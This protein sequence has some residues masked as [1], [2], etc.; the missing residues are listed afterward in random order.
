MLM[1]LNWFHNIPMSCDSLEVT[2]LVVEW[3][4]WTQG[5]QIQDLSVTQMCGLK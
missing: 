5:N 3:E 1:I 4:L 2:D